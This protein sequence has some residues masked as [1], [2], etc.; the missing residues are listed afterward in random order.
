LLPDFEVKYKGSN[1]VER[2]G[3]YY[4]VSDRDHPA[5]VL[6]QT[7]KKISRGMAAQISLNIRKVPF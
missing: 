6:L 7:A 1:A 3:V 2:K 4:A 5:A